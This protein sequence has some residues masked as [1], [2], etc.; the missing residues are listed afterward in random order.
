[1]GGR[2]HFKQDVREGLFERVTSELM[3]S[4]KKGQ[5]T[6][7]WRQSLLGWENTKYRGPQREGGLVDLSHRKVSVGTE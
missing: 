2:H 1:M 7:I 3:P 5:A 4:D 6:K